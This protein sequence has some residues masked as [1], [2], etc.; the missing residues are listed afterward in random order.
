MWPIALDIHA[1]RAPAQILLIEAEAATARTL[2]L[3]EPVDRTNQRFGNV[4]RLSARLLPPPSLPASQPV[5]T[6]VSGKRATRSKYG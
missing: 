2:A 1:W 4:S 3:R 6:V 5:L